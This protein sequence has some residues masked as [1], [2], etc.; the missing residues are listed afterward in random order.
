MW[1]VIPIMLLGF[2]PLIKMTFFKGEV[3]KDLTVGEIQTKVSGRSLE[4][5]G[6]ITNSSR[7]EWSSVTVEAEFF[8]DSGK[9]VDEAI[10]YLRSDI[11][12]NSKEHFKI[13]INS[14]PEA[15]L[16]G[17]IKPVVKIS[18]GHTSPF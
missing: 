18:G 12:G 2:L 4:I 10:E 5:I 16:N 6:L 15:A 8:D 9:F 1:L 17:S 3:T 11:G 13:V 7:S 14:P